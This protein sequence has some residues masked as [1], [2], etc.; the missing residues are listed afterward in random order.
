MLGVVKLSGT[1]L[2]VRGASPPR[3]RYA[4][5]YVDTQG[6]EKSTGTGMCNRPVVGIVA[7]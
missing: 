1:T 2:R 7:G 5:A 3:R 6:A 4:S